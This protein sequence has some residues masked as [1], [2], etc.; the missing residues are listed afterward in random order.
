MKNAV[1][2]KTL[3]KKRKKVSVKQY[4]LKSR[5]DFYNGKIFFLKTTT[6]LTCGN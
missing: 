6:P 5:S 2:W 3:K 1:K 4:S